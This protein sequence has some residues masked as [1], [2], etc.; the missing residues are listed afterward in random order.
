[1]TIFF[2]LSRLLRVLELSLLFNE[3]RCCYYW[4]FPF[5]RAVNML[6]VTFTH[7]PS[8]TQSLIYSSLYWLPGKLLLNLASTVILDSV[9]HGTYDTILFSDGSG[10]LHN[11]LTCFYITGFGPCYLALAR[12]SLET[13]FP[14]FLCSCVL[15]RC[16][17]YMYLWP[18]R[19]V[20]IA[21]A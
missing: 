20:Y 4:S 18:W 12:S 5:Y 1:M 7:S 3:K 17:K 14:W 8:F 19:C 11:P 13:S 15:I 21:V 16:R 10:S 9:S 2:V 6:A